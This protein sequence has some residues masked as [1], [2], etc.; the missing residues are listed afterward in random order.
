MARNLL[1]K[2]LGVVAGIVFLAYGVQERQSLSRIKKS[3]QTAVV[4]PVQQ[5]TEIKKS[6]QSLYT[7]EIVF[8]TQAGQEIRTKRSFPAEVLDDFKKGNPVVVVYRAND[9]HTFVFEKEESSWLLPAIG[10]G[11]AV[12]SLVLL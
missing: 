5:Y 3:G 11:I 1:F 2:A 7:A 6:G 8:K 10:V 4:Q 12:A 9:P